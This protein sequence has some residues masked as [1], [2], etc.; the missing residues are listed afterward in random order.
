MKVNYEMKTFNYAKKTK[1]KW[2]FWLFLRNTKDRGS[3][4]DN[5]NKIAKAQDLPQ[6]RKS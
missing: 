5:N 1:L 6:I 3:L 2:N 4:Q